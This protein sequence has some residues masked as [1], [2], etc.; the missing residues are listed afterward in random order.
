MWWKKASCGEFDGNLMEA[1]TMR[2]SEFPIG[3]KPIV[4]QGTSIRRN[5]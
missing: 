4:E 2:W 1:E 3:G 5:K